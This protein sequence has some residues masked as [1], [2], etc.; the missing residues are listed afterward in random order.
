MSMETTLRKS[1]SRGASPAEADEPVFLPLDEET[2]SPPTSDIHS[3]DEIV[4]SAAS[5]SDHASEPSAAADQEAC[6]VAP[7][8]GWMMRRKSSAVDAATAE[9]APV[10]PASSATQIVRGRDTVVSKTMTGAQP[11]V[12]AKSEPRS[13][14]RKGL[15]G[16]KQPRFDWKPKLD[17]PVEEKPGTLSERVT[18]WVVGVAA[19]GYGV[20]LILHAVVLLGLGFVVVYPKLVNQPGGLTLGSGTGIDT[21]VDFGPISLDNGGGQD[22]GSTAEATP[23]LNILPGLLLDQNQMEVPQIASDLLGSGA[24]TSNQGTGTGDS[25]GHGT[26]GGIGNGDGKGLPFHMPGGGGKVVT[27][28]SFTAWTVPE[29]PEPGQNYI[30]VIQF[31]VPDNVRNKIPRADLVG[32]MVVGTDGYRQMIPGN[33]H[34][35]LPGD[36]KVVQLAVSVP[37]AGRLVRDTITVK[38]KMLKE[39]QVLTIE[40]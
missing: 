17:E 3:G 19:M 34:G 18:K 5:E 7:P 9:P 40:F 24:G 27:K 12:P 8:P 14:I 10:E 26:G 16:K 25:K 28:G 15:K 11:A 6:P 21:E 36:G 22:A 32:S 31:K 23:E 1:S 37:G 29:D 4:F 13:G 2:G 35:Y 33:T 39:E 20:S 30:I 38:S